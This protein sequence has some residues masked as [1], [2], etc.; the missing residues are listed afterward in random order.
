[1]AEPTT[2]LPTG[3]RPRLRPVDL[4]DATLMVLAESGAH[5]S[6]ERIAQAACDELANGREVCYLVLGDM[7]KEASGKGVLR[8]LH[9]K[10]SRAE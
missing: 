2:Q 7:I 8:V 9:Q 1:M 6:L 4:K 10:Y 5:S 3:G